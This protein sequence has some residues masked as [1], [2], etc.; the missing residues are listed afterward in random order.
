[1]AVNALG[2]MSS[3]KSVDPIVDSSVFGPVTVVS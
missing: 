1:M 2:E 3:E